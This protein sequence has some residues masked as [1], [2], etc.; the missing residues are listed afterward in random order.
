M[1]M[2]SQDPKY[3]SEYELR[4]MRDEERR[5]LLE[6]EDK[7][8]QISDKQHFHLQVIQSVLIVLLFVALWSWLIFMPI[9][10]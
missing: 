4:R 10:S 2:N 6:E 5:R 1:N 7:W 3:H 9:S 8:R